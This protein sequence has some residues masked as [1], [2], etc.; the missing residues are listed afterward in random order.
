[1]ALPIKL[2]L[3]EHF[4]EEEVRCGYTVTTKLK[5][6]WAVELDLLNEFQRVCKKYDIKYTVFGGTLLGGVRHKGFIPWDDD[7]DVAL[8]RGEFDKLCFVAEKEFEDPYC[9]QT[10]LSD[11]RFFLPFARLRNGETTAIINGQGDK[12][13]NNGIYI[14]IYVLEGYVDSK[15]KWMFQNCLLKMMVKSLTLYY[16]DA[17]RNNSFKESALRLLRPFVRGFSY[18]TLYSAYKKVLGM[19]TAKSERIGLRDEMS[20]QAKR[21]WLYKDEMDEMNEM[22][23]E[24][25]TVPNPRHYD[26]ILR[27]IYGD[28][29]TF[30]K[31][32]IRGTWHNGQIDFDPDLP[33][34]A[35]FDYGKKS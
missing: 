23:F 1:M 31:V 19:Y 13:Y 6:I 30:P 26:A 18:E 11:R 3:P 12:D 20:E 22:P 25:L 35:Y 8:T 28:Y 27:R 10:A 4:L 7:L 33:Y 29:M 14:D 24:F 32:S 15:I 16:Q 17:K 5:K 2:K 9:F 34:T 21:Y